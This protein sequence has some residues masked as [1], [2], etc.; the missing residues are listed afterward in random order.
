M[1]TDQYGIGAGK[2]GGSLACP[3]R[4]KT[5]P[6]HAAAKSNDKGLFFVP[7][8]LGLSG[9][10]KATVRIEGGT[11]ENCRRRGRPSIWVDALRRRML[12]VA[13]LDGKQWKFALNPPDGFWK[14]GFDAGS[15]SAIKVPA[16]WEMEGFHSIDNVG[17]YI[18]KFE[19]P[20][21][22]GQ[23]RNCGSTA[24][25]AAPKSG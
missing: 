5:G 8:P 25:T 6:W 22:E 11:S 21:G 7:M 19:L 17:G 16:H 13:K 4:R 1:V 14:P 24:F 15:W 10:V 23:A 12:K 20:A 3:A 9:Q 2:R 18:R